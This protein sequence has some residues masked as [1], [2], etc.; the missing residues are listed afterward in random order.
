MHFHSGVTLGLLSTHCDPGGLA[1]TAV[2]YSSLIHVADVKLFPYSK[3]VFFPK[4]NKY[5]S[6]SR[7]FKQ[8][9]DGVFFGEDQLTIMDG[10]SSICENHCVQKSMELH[11][12]V[13][14]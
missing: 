1:W 3:Y 2:T 7:R 10:L 6:F 9:L 4:M 5:F 14:L 13:N 11:S 12:G 8:K